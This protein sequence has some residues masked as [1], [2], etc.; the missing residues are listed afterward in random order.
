MVGILIMSLLLS[1]F[2]GCGIL[3]IGVHGDRTQTK[4]MV[5]VAVL[6]VVASVVVAI[7]SSSLETALFWLPMAGVGAGI[8]TTLLRKLWVEREIRWWGRD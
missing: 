7:A 5:G 1:V 2:I 3:T 4:V 6:W 8:T